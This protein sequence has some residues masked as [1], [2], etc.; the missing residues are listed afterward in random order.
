VTG[1]VGW[2][3]RKYQEGGAIQTTMMRRW[4]SQASYA[5]VPST[6]KPTPTR[7]SVIIWTRIDETSEKQEKIKR[8]ALLP[9]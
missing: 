2:P 4:A 8:P 1:P 5:E 6:T 7:P 9:A 3:A